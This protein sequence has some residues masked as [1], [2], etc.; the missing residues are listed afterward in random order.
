MDKVYSFIIFKNHL[1]VETPIKTVRSKEEAIEYCNRR[2]KEDTGTYYY[3]RVER[4]P[5]FYNL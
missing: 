4:E 3:Q 1:G 2:N 5:G